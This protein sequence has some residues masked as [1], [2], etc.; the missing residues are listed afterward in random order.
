MSEKKKY[1]NQELLRW[2]G[3]ADD[4]PDQKCMTCGAL[5]DSVKRGDFLCALFG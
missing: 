2:M 3:E 4:F 5:H 1:S